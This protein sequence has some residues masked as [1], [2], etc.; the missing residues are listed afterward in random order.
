MKEGK[1]DTEE[2]LLYTENDSVGHIDDD[3]RGG[4]VSPGPWRC[5]LRLWGTP[6]AGW[7]T[8][9]H[10]KLPAAAME[11]SVFY[12]LSALASAAAFARKFYF[13]DTTVAECLIAATCI[14]V[15][16]F[17]A[18]FMVFPL[19]RLLLRRD[20]ADR[21]DTPFGHCYVSSLMA[22]L[23]LFYFLYECMPFL[24]V[25]LAFTP[26][27][28]VYIAYKGMSVFR[29]PESKRI[30]AWVVLI[31]LTVGLPILL[32]QSLEMLLPANII[33]E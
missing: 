9:R 3:K 25:V 14:F 16:F 28:T 7:K 2:T 20:C 12:P 26:A 19:A 10:T 5:W 21:I 24:E 17:A 1:E 29:I 27:Y 15:A 32:Y 18:Y 30:L 31:L 6:L 8:I 11:S 33:A 22:S 23:A 4:R 13:P